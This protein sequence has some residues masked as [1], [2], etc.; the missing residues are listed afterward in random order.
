MIQ[1]SWFTCLKTVHRSQMSPFRACFGLS[2]IWDDRLN[3]SRLHIVYP[4][5]NVYK[6]DGKITMLLMGKL[7]ISTG[8]FSIAMLVYQR[9][10][11]IKQGCFNLSSVNHGLTLE[12]IGNSSNCQVSRDP[13]KRWGLYRAAGEGDPRSDRTWVW[14]PYPRIVPQNGMYLQ[15]KDNVGEYDWICYKYIMDELF[16]RHSDHDSMEEG[17]HGQIILGS[18]GNYKTYLWKSTETDDKPHHCKCCSTSLVKLTKLAH[19]VG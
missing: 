8:P 2:Q 11:S 6:T 19:W 3:L 15:E 14:S 1:P 10:P 5:V 18:W 7:T 13:P 4:L 12:T 9:V 17:K 16:G